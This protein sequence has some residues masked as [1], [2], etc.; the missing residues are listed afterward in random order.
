MS[1]FQ[2]EGLSDCPSASYTVSKGRGQD[3]NHGPQSHTPNL[4]KAGQAFAEAD[5]GQMHLLDPH[6]LPRRG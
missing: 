6:G 4:Y 5:E 3:S 1:P 2:T